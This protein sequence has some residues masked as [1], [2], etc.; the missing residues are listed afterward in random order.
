[1]ILHSLIAFTRVEKLSSSS[2]I[3]DAS[4]ATSVHIFHI[5]THIFASLS[6]GASFTQSQVTAIILCSFLSSHTILI[7]SSGDVLEKIT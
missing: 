2:T 7:L 6:A 1:M 3:S 4:L 5:A